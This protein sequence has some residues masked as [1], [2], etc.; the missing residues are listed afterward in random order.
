M[1]P[2]DMNTLEY[3]AEIAA[4]GIRSLKIEGRMK[5]PEYV[6]TVVRIYRKYLDTGLEQVEKGAASKLSIDE[7]DRKDLLQIFNRGGFSPGYL[8]GKTGAD[9]MSYEKPNNS[10][11]CIGS[12][13]SYD[14]RRKTVRIR[15]EDD[16]SIGDGIEI[17]TGGSDSPGGTVS[18]LK[19]DGRNVKKAAKGDSVEAGF[20]SGESPGMKVYKTTDAELIREARRTFSDGNMKR[21]RSERCCPEKTIRWC[22]DDDKGTDVFS[23][24]VH[25]ETAV[26]RP[27]PGKADCAVEKDRIY[28]FFIRLDVDMQELTIPISE[29]NEKESL[30][31]YMKQTGIRTGTAITPAWEMEMLSMR[32][33]AGSTNRIRTAWMTGQF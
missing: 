30:K 6:A 23:G 8:K 5:S 2:K 33:S 11:I 29:I 16:L 12:T 1:S 22:Q 21:I 19:K 20:F 28:A 3:I 17:W 13:I 9:M 26:N 25:A 7:R 31:H 27:L 24:S 10:G 14:R 32:I 15:L 18:L 4:S